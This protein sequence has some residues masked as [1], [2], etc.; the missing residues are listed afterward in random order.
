MTRPA[1]TCAV[2]TATCQS[3]NPIIPTV[4]ETEHLAEEQHPDGAVHGGKY[5]LVTAGRL[6]LPAQARRT[7]NEKHEGDV[8]A[9]RC[10]CGGCRTRR[11]PGFVVGRSA[12][13][14]AAGALN[15]NLTQY[16]AS[17][18]LTAAIEGDPLTVS[19]NGQGTSQLRARF[20]ITAARRRF[21]TCRCAAAAASGRASGRT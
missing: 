18:G 2:S 5:V 9:R 1:T 3:G 17:N 8:F 13:N 20:A 15:C 19:W 10:G 4:A 14:Q 7:G 21:A 6:H 12:A 11:F 16:K